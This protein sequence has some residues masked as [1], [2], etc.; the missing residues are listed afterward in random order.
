MLR[1]LLAADDSA[2]TALL[3]LVSESSSSRMARK[4][5]WAG[6]AGLDSPELW[7]F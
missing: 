2:A 4:R 6:S 3:R 7:A 5:C 1:K